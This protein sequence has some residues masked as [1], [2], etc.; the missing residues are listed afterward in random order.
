MFNQMLSIM[1]TQIKC[2]AIL[3]SLALLVGCSET[4]EIDEVSI[5]AQKS[6][7]MKNAHLKVYPST[8]GDAFTKAEEDWLNISDALQNAGSGEVVQ[9][10]EGLFYLPKS[11]I[12][13]DFNGT[14]KGSGMGETTIQTV[15]GELF[16][17]SECPPINWTFEENDGGFLLCFPQHFTEE[18]RTVTVSD[19]SIIVSV[20]TTPYI[21]WKNSPKEM[22]FNSLEAINV[23]YENLDNDME[24]PINLN[25]YYKNLHITGVK[26]E[27]Y[28]Y[29]GFSIFTGLAAFGL[30]DGTFEAKNVHIENASGCVSPYAFYGDNASVSLKNSTLS[31]CF[32]GIYSFLNHSWTILNN[33]VEN[34]T[35]ALVLLKQR[36]SGELIEG[37]DGNSWIK[38]NRIHFNGVLGLGVQNVKNVEVKDNF[39]MGRGQFGGI[40][41]I[42]G[43]NWIIKNNNLC[44]VVPISPFNCTIFL[45][46]LANSEIKNNANQIIGGPGS[47]DP[48][49]IIGEGIECTE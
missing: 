5:A 4:N 21:R 40:A 39:F 11:I 20:P 42:N 28:N 46:N 48:S 44:G 19:L 33:Q 10:A 30:S 26:D 47:N 2:F 6:M 23:H 24:H 41:A 17:V 29:N 27:K 12:R 37:P 34:S 14:L 18:A 38:G 45:N 25:V 9:L 15:P 43:A 8:A 1:K 31:S 7:N 13:W 22:E 3:Y 16:D 49:N 35:L 32:Y 36:A